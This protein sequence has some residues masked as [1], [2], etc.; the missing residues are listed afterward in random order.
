M[1]RAEEWRARIADLVTPGI[2]TES[3]VRPLALW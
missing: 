2:K 3:K 1:R